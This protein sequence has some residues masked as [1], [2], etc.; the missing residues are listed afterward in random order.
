M[1]EL[2]PIAIYLQE[3]D[4]G[5]IGVNIFIGEFPASC[6]SGILLLDRV[7]SPVNMEMPRYRDTGFRLIQR[8]PDY[9]TGLALITQTFNALT[10]FI[11]TT[12]SGI[13]IKL[14]VPQSD[15]HAY[16]RSVAG[17]WEFEVDFR[18]VYVI[19]NPDLRV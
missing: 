1:M 16:R 11:E 2:K 17:V 9:E 4:Q 5:T 8:D 12:V 18:I 19:N 10:L 13:T 3:Q 6:A 15:P 14:M 7:S